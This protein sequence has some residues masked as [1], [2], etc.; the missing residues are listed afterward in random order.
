MKQKAIKL[1]YF[2]ICA[3]PEWVMKVIAYLE[4]KNSYFYCAQQLV[5]FP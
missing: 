3:I 5:V 2:G 1:I 4:R